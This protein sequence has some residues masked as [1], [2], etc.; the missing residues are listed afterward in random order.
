VKDWRDG[1]EA[2]GEAMVLRERWMGACRGRRN[3]R[4]RAENGGADFT[5]LQM[6]TSQQVQTFGKKKTATAVALARVSYGTYETS[7]VGA[8]EMS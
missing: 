2:E 8:N 7:G 5:S 4:E 1:S 6:S 3:R